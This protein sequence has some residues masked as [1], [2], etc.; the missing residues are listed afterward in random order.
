MFL[1]IYVPLDLIGNRSENWKL[2]I[3]KRASSFSSFTL[4]SAIPV[5]PL[6]TSRKIALHLSVLRTEKNLK[7]F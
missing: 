6:A 2:E 5:T 3:P 7:C 4:V 1:K